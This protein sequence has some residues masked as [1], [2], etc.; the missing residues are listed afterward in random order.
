[1]WASWSLALA[2]YAFALLGYVLGRVHA[3]ARHAGQQLM[4]ERRKLEETQR[5]LARR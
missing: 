2:P 3:A 5:A 4:Q 1:M